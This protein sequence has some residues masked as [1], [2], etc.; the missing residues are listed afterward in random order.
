MRCARR[1]AIAG[2]SGFGC[3]SM[4][5]GLVVLTRMSCVASSIA[6]TREKVSVAAR[7]DAY[8]APPRGAPLR[9]TG[10]EVDDPTAPTARDHRAGRGLRHEERPAAING[11][12][13]IPHFGPLLEQR[14]VRGDRGVVDAYVEPAERRHGAID[15]RL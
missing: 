11:I 6:A 7:L 3:V 4:R 14:R 12:H 8:A 1:S 9:G 2:G 13:A 10:R 5:P 15:D